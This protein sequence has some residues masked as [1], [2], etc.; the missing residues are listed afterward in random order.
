MRF[1]SGLHISKELETKKDKMIEMIE[2]NKILFHTYLITVPCLS[3]EQLEIFDVLLKHQDGFMNS[4][5][6]IV[7]I[8][9]SYS[10]SLVLVEEIVKKVYNETRTANV[11]E[12]FLGQI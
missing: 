10:D 6:L 5:D 9:N 7:G 12:Y 2:S 4:D 1:Y 3:D 8:A 11:R